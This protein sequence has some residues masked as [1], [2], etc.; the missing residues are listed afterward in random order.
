MLWN[1][2][3]YYTDK[4]VRVI[5][6]QRLFFVNE[7]PAGDCWK[8]FSFTISEEFRSVLLIW[9]NS[10]EL[11]KIATKRLYAW[12]CSAC[13]WKSINLWTP[14][15]WKKNKGSK[16]FLNSSFVSFISLQL[17]IGSAI[18]F[19]K[20]AYCGP[21]DTRTDADVNRMEISFSFFGF[22]VWHFVPLPK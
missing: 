14:I 10:I 12:A 17:N 9:W 19:H 18:A 7:S 2:E 15:K 4:I 21:R 20:D 16:F 22:Y 13:F 6:E 11:L 1:W 3:V 8:L 5:R